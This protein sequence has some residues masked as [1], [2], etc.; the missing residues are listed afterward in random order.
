MIKKQKRVSKQPKMYISDRPAKVKKAKKGNTNSSTARNSFSSY[1]KE[2]IEKHK[3][4][5]KNDFWGHESLR[6]D[7]SKTKSKGGKKKKKLKRESLNN[8]PLGNLKTG[9]SQATKF[10][11]FV[12]ANKDNDW[13]MKLEDLQENGISVQDCYRY[14]MRN[15]EFDLNIN[16][17][18]HVLVGSTI[19]PPSSERNPA[20]TT[21]E[22]T[23]KIHESSDDNPDCIEFWR[24]LL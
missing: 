22:T 19:N 16:D 12:I 5:N 24:N 6:R 7:S 17:D 4:S 13:E 11:T 14:N 9:L 2:P 3:S 15:N 8:K 21:G 20:E 1:H 10:S 18:D 23:P